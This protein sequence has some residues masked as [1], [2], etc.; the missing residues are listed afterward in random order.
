M[1][2]YKILFAVLLCGFFVACEQ[3][4]SD[5]NVDPDASTQGSPDE[6]FVSA[7]GFYG[8]GLEIANEDNAVLAQ[9]WAGGPGV[10]LIDIER[11][12]F[13]PADFNTFWTYSYLQTLTDLKYVID[14]GNEA[15]AAAANIFAVYVMQYLVDLFGDVPY[16]SANLGAP[17]SGGLLNPEYDSGED[18]YTD[19]IAR[20]DTS[21]TVLST[22]ADQL[23]NEDLIYEGNSNNWV[24]FA[25]SL[26]LRLLMRQSI[27]DPSVGP[28]VQELIA[29][30]TFITSEDQLAAIPFNG[31]DGQNYNPQ[32][33]RRE[34]GVGQ[35]FVA[36]QTS[37]STLDELQDPRDSA[38]YEVAEA[39]GTIVGLKQGNVQVQT[40]L[41]AADLSAPSEIAYAADNPVILMSHWEVMFLRA[42][43]DM[44]FGTADDE[45]EMFNSAVRAHFDY[46]GASGV[47][48]YLSNSVVYNASASTVAK[49]NMIGIQKWISMNGL[50]ET[51]GWIEAR[52]FDYP[53]AGNI[54]TNP[55]DGIFVT[56]TASVLGNNVFPSIYLYP[57]SEFDYNR[58]NVPTGRT[59]TSNVFWDN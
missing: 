40:D 33:A 10:S 26:K 56:P 43:A 25:N 29:S 57:Q 16:L 11:Y 9:Y 28:A 38:L 12:F 4:L 46:V 19:L 15:Q 17:E 23:G 36:S 41:S 21:A 39:T 13:V 6:L 52:R 20:L 5:L 31:A 37:T 59:I 32:F 54:F 18:I 30:G 49:S 22:T 53:D 8:I 58:D 35:F 48:N 47:A 27:T 50:Q 3:D 2:I 55:T 7:S 51:E 14:N 42:E 45:T 1:K 24:R 44:R 34:G